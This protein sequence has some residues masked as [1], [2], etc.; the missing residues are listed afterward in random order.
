MIKFNVQ[1]SSKLPSE[2]ALIKKKQKK[3]SLQRRMLI[4]CLDT[5]SSTKRSAFAQGP[6]FQFI[7]L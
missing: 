3:R 6:N 5:S 1:L 7:D 4:G 2:S